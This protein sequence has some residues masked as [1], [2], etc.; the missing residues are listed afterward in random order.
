MTDKEFDFWRDH[1]LKYL[2]TL[3]KNHKHCSE[4]A[5]GALY[6]ALADYNKKE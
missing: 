1:S 3:P 6:K 2:E 4:L 5:V